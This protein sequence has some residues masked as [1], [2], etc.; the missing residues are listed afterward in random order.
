MKNG[1]HLCALLCAAAL[2]I[3]GTLTAC[4]TPP[5]GPSPAS[6]APSADGGTR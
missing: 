5:A 6:S 1:K 3:G 2:L 4:G